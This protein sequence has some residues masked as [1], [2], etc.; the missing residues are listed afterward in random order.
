MFRLIIRTIVL[1]LALA[2]P[3]A[4]AESNAPFPDLIT[5]DGKPVTNE[6]DVGNG[7][8]QLVMIW[9]TD[10]HICS[11]MKPKMSAFH[12]KHKDTDAQVYGVALDGAS[13]LADVQKYMTDHKV[14]FPTYIGEI[15]LIAVNF[16]INSQTQLRGTPT[17]LLFSPTG[18]LMAIDFG[19]LDVDSIERFMERNS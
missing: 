5:I 18:E 12:D 14:T 16:E 4:W 11:V 2:A 19:M 6:A 9:A 3:Q 15:G 13:K 10:C 8:W 17:Y 1:T 7:K